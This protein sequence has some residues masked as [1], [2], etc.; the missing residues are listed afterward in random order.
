[1]S[2]ACL[3]LDS[4]CK[5]IRHG[6]LMYGPRQIASGARQRNGDGAAWRRKNPAHAAC[7]SHAVYVNRKQLPATVRALVGFL[8]AHPGEA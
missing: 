4:I 3:F 5:N 6:R 8:A 2:Q 7:A 1:M